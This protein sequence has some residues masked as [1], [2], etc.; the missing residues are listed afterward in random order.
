MM[1]IFKYAGP[2]AYRSFVF[3]ACLL[4][5]REELSVSPLFFCSLLSNGKITRCVW[6]K[7]SVVKKTR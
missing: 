2:N 7:H 3:V 5:R 1:V 6:E 4:K